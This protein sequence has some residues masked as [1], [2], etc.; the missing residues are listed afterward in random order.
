MLFA[1]AS[2]MAGRSVHV[3]LCLYEPPSCPFGHDVDKSVVLF[4][5]NANDTMLK[6]E[7]SQSATE[8][9]IKIGAS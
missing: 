5:Y 9:K 7:Q 3:R 2:P 4:N 1:F 8:G 6:N